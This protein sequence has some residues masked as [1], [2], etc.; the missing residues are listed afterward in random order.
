MKPESLLKTD[1][2]IDYFFLSIVAQVYPCFKNVANLTTK[3]KKEL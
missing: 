3:M 2:N 1:Y